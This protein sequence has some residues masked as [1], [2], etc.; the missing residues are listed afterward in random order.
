M[1][2]IRFP[3]VNTSD[4]KYNFTIF[5]PPGRQEQ[6]QNWF[7]E[8]NST[9]EVDLLEFKQLNNIPSWYHI[10]GIPY[11]IQANVDYTPHTAVIKLVY[12]DKSED[13]NIFSPYMGVHSMV[14]TFT[15]SY[16]NYNNINL[17]VRVLKN[18][19]NQPY[20]DQAIYIPKAQQKTF[21]NFLIMKH[22]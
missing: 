1:A 18:F 11:T 6:L 7:Y 13:L 15:Y 17:K 12:I 21:F 22:T 20:I 2:I 10:F 19:I 9:E 4:P 16:Y 14:T 5:H 3:L 8:Q